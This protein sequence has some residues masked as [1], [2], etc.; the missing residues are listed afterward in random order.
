MEA[1]EGGRY[2]LRR[3]AHV[4]EDSSEPNNVNEK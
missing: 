1:G 2:K 3:M 4:G